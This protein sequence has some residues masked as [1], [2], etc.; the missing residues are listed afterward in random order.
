MFPACSSGNKQAAGGEA[1]PTLG[2]GTNAMA[3]AA[4][5]KASGVEDI[6]DGKRYNDVLRIRYLHLTGKEVMGDSILIQTPDGKSMLID[7]G[8]P[9]AGGQVVAYAKKLGLERIDIALN[10]HPHT[11][12]IGG[13]AAIANLLQIGEFYMGN[14]PYPGSQSYEKTVAAIKG[15]QIPIK[16][17]ERGDSFHLGKEVRIDVLNPPAGSLPGDV[18]PTDLPK[19]NSHSLVLQLHY[20]GQSFLFNGDIYK[21]REQELIRTMGERLSS[22]AMHV[23][24]HGSTTSSSFAFIQAVK[25]Q[26]AI[27]SNNHFKN[28]D[29]LRLYDAQKTKVYITEKHGNIML[30]FDGKQM[31]VITE[32]E[33]LDPPDFLK[34]Q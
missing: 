17:L 32:K 12:H 13:F 15:K 28:W 1:Q 33:W 11:D 19:V 6:F 3:P 16:Y 9:G 18:D 20:K 24:H 23:A 2:N 25:P 22:S 7:G 29:L 4:K 21:D 14:L 26:A 30:T 34:N 10:T 31:K 27:I 5:G 8:L